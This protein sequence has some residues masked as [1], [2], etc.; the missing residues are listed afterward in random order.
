MS[1]LEI[2]LEDQRVASPVSNDSHESR[3]N[4]SSLKIRI[5]SLEREAFQKKMDMDKLESKL[6]EQ[7]T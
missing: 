3:H 6:V 1:E 4:V 5:K 7:R 2:Q